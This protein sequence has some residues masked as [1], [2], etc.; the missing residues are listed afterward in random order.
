MPYTVNSDNLPSYVKKLSTE[1]RKKWV[2]I[3][4]RVYEKEGE[5]MAFIVANKWLERN[6]KSKSTESRTENVKERVTF[7]VDSSKEFIQRTDDGEEYISFKL[8]ETGVDKLGKPWPEFMLKEWADQI[9]SGLTVVGDVDHKIM[10][11]LLSSNASDEEIEQTLRDKPS[12]A[13]AIRAIY[14]KGKLWLKAVIDKRYKRLIEDSKGV[15][16]E[17]VVERDSNNNIVGGNLLGFTFGVESDPVFA[18]TEVNP[19]AVA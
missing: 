5:K 4:N 8:A 16:L 3:F 12:I 11:K 18:G 2:E 15:S 10:Q 6:V 14:D 17:A 19:N 1:N 7:V 9:N 13:K